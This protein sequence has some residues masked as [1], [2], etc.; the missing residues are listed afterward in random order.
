[1]GVLDIK[2]FP[3]Y[4]ITY[5]ITIT[6]HSS[7]FITYYITITLHPL[8]FITGLFFITLHPLQIITPFFFITLRLYYRRCL[9]FS[10][11]SKPFSLFLFPMQM[12]LFG[13]LGVF[14]L[15]SLLILFVRD[16]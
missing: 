11:H 13:L 2:C 12:V 9:Y 4:L 14:C 6:L 8:C 3:K 1:M 15:L 7:L 16:A 10:F 5:Y